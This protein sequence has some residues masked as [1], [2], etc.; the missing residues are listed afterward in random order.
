[1][2]FTVISF[3]VDLNEYGGS[4]CGSEPDVSVLDVVFS[5]GVSVSES[6]NDIGATASDSGSADSN[7]VTDLK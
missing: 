4:H 1:M 6:S 5:D 3:F 7:D 2:G